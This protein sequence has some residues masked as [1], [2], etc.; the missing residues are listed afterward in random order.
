MNVTLDGVTVMIDGTAIVGDVSVEIRSG[1]M[2]GVVGPNGSGKSTLLR[3]LYRALRPASGRALIDGDDIWRQLTARQAAQR[4]AIVPQ[5][6][7]IDFDF[8]VREVVAMGRAPHQRLLD[9]NSTADTQIVVDALDTVAMTTFAARLV[10]T[11]SGGERQRV[12]LARALAQQ[13]PVLV[14]DE[15]TNH[16]DIRAQLELLE[17]VRALPTTTIAA[18]HDLDHAASLCDTVTVLAHGRVVASGPPKDVLVPDVIAQVF[19][20]RAHVGTHP[21]TG[22]AHITVAT[23]AHRLSSTTD[24]TSEP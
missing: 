7:T 20:V 13:A 18:L 9:R 23:G 8:S 11:L 19:G 21:L 3:C 2:H 1:E 14:L 15:P 16:L 10:S 4:R 22:R 12:L 5:D 6:S 24:T 17:L